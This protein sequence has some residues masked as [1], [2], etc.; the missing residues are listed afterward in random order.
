MWSSS[1]GAAE[2]SFSVGPAGWTRLLLRDTAWCAAA[3]V[4]ALALGVIGDQLFRRPPFGLQYVNAAQRVLATTPKA[5]STSINLVSLDELDALLGK[6]GVLL[7]DARP[8]LLHE[9]GHL[10]GAKVLSRE[11]FESDFRALEPV[12][13]TPGATLLIYCSDASCE[14]SAIVARWLQ[15]R[16]VGPLLIFPGGFADWEEAGWPVES[17]P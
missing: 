16:G 3:A 2:N 13:R 11:D 7:L 5:A 4:L 17:T 8:R 9:L 15:E 14:D 6:P 12:L 1:S 10:P